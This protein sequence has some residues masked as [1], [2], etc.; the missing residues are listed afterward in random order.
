MVEQEKTVHPRKGKRGPAPTGKGTPIQVRLQPD[1]LAQIDAERAKLDPEPTRPE[2]IR[3][4]LEERM[5]I[6][7]EPLPPSAETPETAPTWIREAAARFLLLGARLIR[8]RKSN[9]ARLAQAA[10]YE[11]L[12]E[13]A[14]SGHVSTKLPPA[15]D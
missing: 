7:V 1:L 4:V 2:F 5:S 12:A 15:R 6:V 11:Q 9:A 13:I 14:R 8:G 10:F 3:Q